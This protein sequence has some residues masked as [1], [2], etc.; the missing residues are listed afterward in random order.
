MKTPD[1]GARLGDWIG[2][3]SGRRQNMSI[4]TVILILCLV[5][6]VH[7]ALWG[8]AEPRTAGALVE[9]KL[10]SVSYNRLAKPSSMDLAVSEALIRAD[11]AAIA[12]LAKA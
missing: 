1:E 10:S 8:I 11:L 2:T 6:G 4:V 3:I 7:L 9:G 12:K 5:A